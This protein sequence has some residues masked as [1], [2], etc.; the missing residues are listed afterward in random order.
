MDMDPVLIAALLKEVTSAA[1]Q[2]MPGR[3][4]IRVWSMSGVERLTFPSGTTAVL[5]YAREPFT[6]EDRALRAADEARVPVPR[7]LGSARRNGLLVMVLEDLG[8]PRRE[9][10]DSEAAIVAAR[11]HAAT[12][13]PSL[14]VLD[15]DTPE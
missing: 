9:A 7:V 1:S 4:P 12:P 8:D 15:E 2:P 14:P 10:T 6:H 13:P 11:L 5:K 3:S